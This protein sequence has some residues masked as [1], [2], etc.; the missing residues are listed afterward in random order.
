MTTFHLHTC[1]YPHSSSNADPGGLPC[2]GR[3]ILDME[4][5]VPFTVG[6]LMHSG[7]L[8]RQTPCVTL[9]CVELSYLGGKFVSRPIM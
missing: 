5:K 3:V 6:G 8:D 1:S 2:L 4:L 9:P 7:Y